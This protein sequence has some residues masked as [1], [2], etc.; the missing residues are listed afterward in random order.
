[1][2][3][4]DSAT[5]RARLPFALLIDRMGTAM[6]LSRGAPVRQ[7]LADGEGREFFAMPAILGDYA[8]LKSL[9]VVPGNRGTERP[10]IAG[11][12][13]LFSLRTGEPLATMDAAELTA[14]RASAVAATAAARLARADAARLLVIGAGHLAPYLVAALAQVRPLRSIALWARD[15]ACAAMAADRAGRLWRTGD[16]CRSRHWPICARRW[17]PR[18]SSRR[19]RARRRR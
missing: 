17:R 1:M 4:F 8:G 9:T 13:T 7:R 6:P 16:I 5:L 15:G 14:R 2:R 3:H 12:F 18:T 11:L 10:V 19:P